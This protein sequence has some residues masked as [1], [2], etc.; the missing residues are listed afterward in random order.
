M[1][2]SNA[3][4]DSDIP[5]ILNTIWENWRVPGG[6][7]TCEGCAANWQNRTDI[8]GTEGER[9]G[10][11]GIAP[12]YGIGS[13]NPNVVILGR[14]PGPIKN[15][16]DRK[17]LDFTSVSFE[18]QYEPELTN[19]AS[20][21][22]RNLKF[23]RPMLKKISRSPYNGYFSQLRK[24]HQYPN[25]SDIDENQIRNQCCG[26]DPDYDGYLESELSSLEPELVI[27]LSRATSEKLLELYQ[28]SVP[29]KNR[30]VSFSEF[31]INGIH[32]SGFNPI[33]HQDLPFSVAPTAHPSMGWSHVSNGLSER[34]IDSKQEHYASLGEAIVSFLRDQTHDPD[35]GS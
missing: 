3:Q 25:G 34:G 20:P 6:S 12:Y 29:W 27:P 23:I 17:N 13:L 19:A 26:L 28:I 7:G 1:T 5:A 33:D 22:T 24:C 35:A 15:K 21:E 4:S 10:V 8:E 32:E 30:S 31:S 11:V 16:Q 9:N 14:E 18:D 2:D